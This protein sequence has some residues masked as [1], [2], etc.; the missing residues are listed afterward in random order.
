[1]KGSEQQQLSAGIHDLPHTSPHAGEGVACWVLADSVGDA[2][3]TA[4]RSV[5]SASRTLS[6]EVS[7]WHLRVIPHDAFLDAKPTGT[8]LT[9]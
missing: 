3:E 5:L 9:R 7:L 6:T 8:P 4:W 1:M 2:A